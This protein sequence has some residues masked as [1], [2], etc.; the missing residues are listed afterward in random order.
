MCSLKAPRF[1]WSQLIIFVISCPEAE[2]VL[3]FVVGW[4][5]S[6]LV[7]SG[8]LWRW[9]RLLPIHCL[10]LLHHWLGCRVGLDTVL[11]CSSRS[12][13]HLTIEGFIGEIILAVRYDGSVPGEVE[14]ILNWP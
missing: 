2:I 8:P 5:G 4:T 9:R 10:G 3:I 7:F 13:G 6:E 11:H 1:S 12:S 14:H